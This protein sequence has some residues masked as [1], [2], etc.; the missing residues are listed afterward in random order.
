MKND[1]ESIF[2]YAGLGGFALGVVIL[3]LV[4]AING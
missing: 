3:L 1:D 2:R 4:L